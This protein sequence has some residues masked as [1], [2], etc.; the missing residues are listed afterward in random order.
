MTALRPDEDEPFVHPDRRNLSLI[1]LAILT[2][3]TAVA[4]GVAAFVVA[5]RAGVD[6]RLAFVAGATLAVA[7]VPFLRSVSARL[8]AQVLTLVSAAGMVRFGL[9]G[10]RAI[11][12]GSAALVAWTVAV[13]VVLVISDRLATDSQPALRAASKASGPGP[14]ARSAVLVTL[15][16]SLFAVL[17]GPAVQRHLSAPSSEGAAPTGDTTNDGGAS[18]L[19]SS[20]ELDMTTRPRLSDRIVLTVDADRPSFWR[21]ETFDAW[22]GRRWTRTQRARFPVGPGGRVQ[23]DPDDLGA[24]GSDV[25]RQRVRV[26]A[27]YADLLYA[28][29]SAVRVQARQTIAQ[30]GDGSLTSPIQPMGRGATYTITSRRVPTSR[31]AT[32]CRHR[33]RSRDH[34]RRLRPDAGRHRPGRRG[35]APHHRRHP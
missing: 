7:F 25:L 30:R 21:G 4:T 17:V 33:R 35:G 22:D 15:A 13:V 26:E 3:A 12:P 6:G 28:A 1:R 31:G 14:L 19:R 32:A 5:S 2:A 11:G 18:Q 23:A 10:G 20:A 9:L 24:S 16:I 29:P 27:P 8:T 34:H